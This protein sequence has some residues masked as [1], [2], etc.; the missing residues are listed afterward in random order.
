MI[1]NLKKFL[2]SSAILAGTI[3]GAGI[4]SLPYVF[5]KTGFL[6]STVYLVLLA[7]IFI[8]LYLMY[9]DV[10]LV[11]PGKH[12]FVGE[13]RKYLGLSGYL[14]AIL[15]A[16]LGMFLVLTVYLILS[17]SFINLIFTQSVGSLTVLIIFW[18]FGSLGILLGIRA[19]GF[20]EVLM[21]GGIVLIVAVL[22]FLGI[23]QFNWVT[24]TKWQPSYFFLPYGPLIFSLAGRVA[25]PELVRRLNKTPPDHHLLKKSIITG[26]LL[27]AVIYLA[28]VL[29][30]TGLSK[31]PTA[32]TPDAVSGLINSLNRE[33]LVILGFL[34][35]FTLLSSY[36]II[37]LNI[38]EILIFDFKIAKGL[39][40]L[41]VILAPLLLYLVGLK[42]FLHLVSLIG[43]VFIALEAI[44]I[45]LMWR[46]SSKIRGTVLFRQLPKFLIYF[47][48]IIFGLGIIYQI[49]YL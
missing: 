15:T 41:I 37:G 5:A 46:Q 23:G 8:L 31:G 33:I 19:I 6:I 36:I 17:S 16:V 47:L 48:L 39:A 13:S 43:G 42:N 28:F 9:A 29:A 34:G 30:V 10:I 2:F 27:P 4:F 1:S 11:T 18:V 21:A 12:Q 20:E 22:F 26:V 40:A 32:I 35:I 7:G 3:I 38:K 45:I 25:I 49:F 44:L 14:I 24:F